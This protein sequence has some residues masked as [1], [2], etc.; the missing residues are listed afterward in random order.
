MSL[1]A[2]IYS[3]IGR[4]TSV[5]DMI[6]IV[7]VGSQI[8]SSLSLLA[9]QSTLMLTELPEMVSVFELIFHLEYSE[10][11]PCNMHGDARIEGYHYCMPLKTLLALNYNSFILTVGI[12]GV[13]SHARDMYGNSHSQG[14]C[15]FLEIP[16]MHK[17]VRY[18]ESL[19]TCRNEDTYELKGVHISNFEVDLCSS[20]VEYCSISNVNSLYNVLVNSAVL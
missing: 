3:N 10:S 5:D 15:V 1:C 4:V 12:I 17:L 6:Q 13:D 9:R 20:S 18:F 14:T 7:T 16:S 11:Y 2:L 19:H 8:Y